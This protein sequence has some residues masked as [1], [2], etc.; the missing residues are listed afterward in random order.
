MNELKNTIIEVF[1]GLGKAGVDDSMESIVAAGL[2]DSLSILE[3][4]NA[5]ED[6]FDIAFEEEDLTLENFDKLATIEQIVA[7]R[8]ADNAG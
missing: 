1:T 7:A 8:L 6:R 4:V 3:L 5:L 2:L